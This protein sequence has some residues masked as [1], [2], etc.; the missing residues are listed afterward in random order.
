MS[1]I[2]REK[3]VQ[4]KTPIKY[5]FEGGEVDATFVTLLAPTSK[6]LVECS[7][8]KQG[9]IRAAYDVQMQN[10]KNSISQ[11]EAPDEDADLTLTSAEVLQVLYLS[12]VDVAPLLLEFKAMTK[13]IALVEGEVKMTAPLFDSLSPNDVNNLLGDYIATFIAASM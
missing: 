10:E 9:F 5:H 8:L 7:R 4:L 1:D 12:A 13:N 11:P 3:I 2:I 6:N